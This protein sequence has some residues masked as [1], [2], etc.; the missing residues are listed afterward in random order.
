MIANVHAPVPLHTPLHP[1]KLEPDAAAAVSVTVVPVAYDTTQLAMQFAAPGLIVTVPDPAPIATS[2]TVYCGG[3]PVRLKFAATNCAAP[4]VTVQ[5][6]VPLHAPAHP[7][8]TELF[9]GVSVST[10]VAPAA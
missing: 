2:T 4:I 9:P 1:P 8:N 5:L 3:W 10:I 7:E 6:P